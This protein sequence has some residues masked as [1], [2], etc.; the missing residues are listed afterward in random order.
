MKSPSLPL[1]KA[2]FAALDTEFGPDVPVLDHIPMA[3]GKVTGP[4]PFIHLADDQVLSDADQCHDPSTTYL[5]VEAY[6][7]AVGKVELKGLTARIVEVLDA[8]LAIDGFRVIGHFVE[9]LRHMKDPDG[10]TAHGVA[11][12]RYRLEPLA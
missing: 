3:A 7:R 1:Q 12:L 8:P 6:S 11:V 2:A 10:V 9:D 5:T 4:F